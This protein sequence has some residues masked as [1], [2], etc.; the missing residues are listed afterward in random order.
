MFAPVI[1]IR[2]GALFFCL[3]SGLLPSLPNDSVK[4]PTSL[5]KLP[6]CLTQQELLEMFTNKNTVWCKRCHGMLILFSYKVEQIVH[7]IYS[8]DIWNLSFFK[9]LDKMALIYSLY[10]TDSCGSVRYITYARWILRTG[11][12]TQEQII[13]IYKEING[14]CSQNLCIL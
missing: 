12:I 14:Y 1:K 6:F 4:C 13:Y 9:G 5:N 3:A 8:M 11:A 7:R 2:F 10:L